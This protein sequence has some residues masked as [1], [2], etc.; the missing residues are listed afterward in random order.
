MIGDSSSIS[1]GGVDVSV[2]NCGA[3]LA[4][5]VIASDATAFVLSDSALAGLGRD[6]LT[7]VERAQLT[8]SNTNSSIDAHHFSGRTT[9]TGGD[10]N[11]TILGGS[12]ADFIGGGAGNDVLLGGAGNDSLTDGVGSDMLFGGIGNDHLFGQRGIV[13]SCGW[14]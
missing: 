4:D 5:V 14:W 9:L 8:T 7:G 1:W 11:D 12:V 10:G 13:G 6:L 3:G 2:E